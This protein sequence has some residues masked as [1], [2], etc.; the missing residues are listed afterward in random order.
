MSSQPLTI[1][2]LRRWVQAGAHWRVVE[3]S[4]QRVV[5]DLC[6][7]TG[8]PMQRASSQ[9]PAVIGYVRTASSGL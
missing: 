8:E 7:C 6:A 9:D 2:D 3:I 1:D 4:A 5:V